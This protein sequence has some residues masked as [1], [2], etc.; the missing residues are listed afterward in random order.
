MDECYEHFKKQAYFV[1]C[2]MC[3]E[4]VCVGREDC[5]E[6]KRFIENNTPQKEG[7]E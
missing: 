1:C 2:P 6:I 4:S 5:A 7:A 3:D